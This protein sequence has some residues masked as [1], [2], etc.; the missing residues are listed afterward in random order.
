MLFQL[1]VRESD[2]SLYSIRKLHISLYVSSIFLIFALNESLIQNQTNES[3]EFIYLLTL[4]NVD[5]KTLA[6]YALIKI[7]YP[8]PVPSSERLKWRKFSFLQTFLINVF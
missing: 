7:D 8:P 2:I 3:P 1:I 5:H 6:A 4:F